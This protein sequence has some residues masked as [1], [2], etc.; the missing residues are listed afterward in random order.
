MMSRDN[1]GTAIR[2]LL[3]HD[4]GR[5]WILTKNF[6]GEYIVTWAGGEYKGRAGSLAGAVAN[7]LCALEEGVV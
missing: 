1:D 3:D 7:V 4:P 6:R 2:T 5:A